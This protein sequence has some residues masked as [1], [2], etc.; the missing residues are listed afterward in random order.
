MDRRRACD[1]K[2][3]TKLPPFLDKHNSEFKGYSSAGELSPGIIFCLTA[4]CYATFFVWPTNHKY[5]QQIRD[6]RD[7]FGLHQGPGQSTKA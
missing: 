3:Q 5:S 2:G 7:M 1:P 4:D 6:T